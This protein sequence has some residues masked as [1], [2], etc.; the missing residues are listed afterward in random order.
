MDGGGPVLVFLH[1][2]LGSAAQWRDLPDVLAARTGCA[3][4]AYS[5]WGHGASEPLPSPRGVRFMH[6]EALRVLP[7]LLDT[8]GVGGPVLVG[9]SDGGSIALIHAAA[10]GRPVRGL[11]LIAPHVFV[12]D[13]TVASIARIRGEYATT[14]LRERLARYH[15][16]VDGAFRGWND[17]WLDPAFRAWNIEE[18]LPAIACPVLVIQGENDEYGTLRQV[19]AIA[20]GVSG[21]VRTLVL[22]GAGHAP[23][24]DRP[25]AVVEE[26]RR[27]VQEILAPRS[28]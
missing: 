19:E 12:E 21:T 16:D 13:L 3:A 15:A 11:V 25:D 6:D 26:I 22:P 10:A 1:E 5:R 20:G 18:L 14:D 7:D 24:R 27:F 2:G 23:H 4:L 17:V 9:H 28:A 8:L